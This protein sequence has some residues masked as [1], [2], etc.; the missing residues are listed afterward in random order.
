MTQAEFMGWVRYRQLR[1]PL[2]PMLR[3]EAAIA[4]L[5]ELVCAAAGIKDRSGAPLTARDFMPWADARAPMDDTVDNLAKLMQGG[6][7]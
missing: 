5:A 3:M 2:N 6:S 7:R 4:T 1:G